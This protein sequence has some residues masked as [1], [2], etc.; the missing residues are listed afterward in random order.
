M[1]SAFFT[2]LSGLRAHARAVE[3]VANNLANLNTLSFKSSRSDFRDLFYQQIGQSRSGVASQ[4]G[5][6]AAPITVSRRFE[7]GTIQNTGGLLDAAIQGEGFF[8][9]RRIFPPPASRVSP[10]TS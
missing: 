3:V 4:V 5:I 2:G 6:G 1:P 7:Q 9:V 10:P 8:V